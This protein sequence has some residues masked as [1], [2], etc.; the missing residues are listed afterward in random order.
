MINDKNT[1]KNFLT[2]V[3][4]NSFWSSL[5]FVFVGITG[6]VVS[7][8]LTRY[9]GASKYGVYAYM[10]S[11]VAILAIVLDFGIGQ[12]I[13]K[14][15]PKYF[16][17]EEKKSIAIKIFLAATYLRL[18]VSVLII[19]ILC[20]TLSHWIGVVNIADPDVRRLLL[21]AILGSLVSFLSAHLLNFLSATQNFKKVAIANI[22][23]STLNIIFILAVIFLSKGIAY[24]LAASIL[25][26]F[27]VACY[28]FFQVKPL[29][30]YKEFP[31]TVVDRKEIVKYTWL[32]YI[33]VLVQFVL[34][35]Y[36]EVIFLGKYSPSAEIGFYSLA[37][38]MAIIFT[39]FVGVLQKSLQ[40]AQFEV[41][42]TEEKRSD[43]MCYLAIK[44]GLILF[45]PIANLL[46]LFIGNAV[47]LV[48]GS[49]FVK[50]QSIFPLVLYSS[51]IGVIFTPI[52]IKIANQNKKFSKTILIIL[53]GAVLNLVLDY[54][55]IRKYSSIGAGVANF[56]SQA[57]TTTLLLTYVLR[58]TR[59]Y[60]DWRKVWKLLAWAVIFSLLFVAL[61]VIT[62][63]VI[64][65]LIAGI[66]L[67]FLSFRA[68]VWLKVFCYEDVEIL[69]NLMGFS[70]RLLIPIVQKAR[71]MI[72]KISDNSALN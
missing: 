21:I 41:L 58:S 16:W 37:Y 65:K 19:A 17:Y 47:N 29:L 10:T 3:T 4:Q 25:T 1:N 11:L 57:V 36:S 26:N 61:S 6:L 46:V 31:E 18:I 53:L 5:N 35:S 62:K 33:N 54:F 30:I 9:F 27:A 22:V 48:Y 7:I 24:I 42:E 63:L 59:Y 72:K 44:Y 32:A 70:P 71:N 66:I 60:I 14:Y 15:V 64:I 55:L 8:I 50:I 12:A 49:G 39:S 68:L 2:I 38:T 67:L 20:L 51:I 40:N 56:L 45:I 28:A 43:R 23:G 34:W 13:N 52:F 69:D